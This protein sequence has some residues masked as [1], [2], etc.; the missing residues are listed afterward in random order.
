[1]ECFCSRLL[2]YDNIK[3]I[4]QLFATL[5]DSLTNVANF[6]QFLDIAWLYC[7][8][9]HFQKRLLH[10][11]DLSYKLRYFFW[12]FQNDLANG[13]KPGVFPPDLGIQCLSGF[14]F[15]RSAGVFKI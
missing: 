10:R 5:W 15:W 11:I 7:Y 12:F 3:S 14:F 1:M 9:W 8:G 6:Q 2:W 4:L 13:A